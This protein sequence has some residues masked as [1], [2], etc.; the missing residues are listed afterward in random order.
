MVYFPLW[1]SLF[2]VSWKKL[3]EDE[4]SQ[5]LAG[6]CPF[7]SELWHFRFLTLLPVRFWNCCL[8]HF[9]APIYLCNKGRP[10][11]CDMGSKAVPKYS[12]FTI[13]RVWVVVVAMCHAHQKMDEVVFWSYIDNSISW[14]WFGEIKLF[15]LQQLGGSNAFQMNRKNKQK[16]HS[17]C[18]VQQLLRNQLFV[19]FWLCKPPDFFTQQRFGSWA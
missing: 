2:L 17:V 10:N 14:K 9:W 1:F 18:H 11:F 5:T 8:S 15:L 7:L 3:I 13:F 12:S 16:F 19:F 4:N 6:V